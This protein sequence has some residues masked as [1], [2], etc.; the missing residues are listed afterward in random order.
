MYNGERGAWEREPCRVSRFK[1]V[2]EV[3]CQFHQ[4]DE[5]GKPCSNSLVNLSVE[6]GLL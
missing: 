1:L 4:G 3:L 6:T 2:A 5:G